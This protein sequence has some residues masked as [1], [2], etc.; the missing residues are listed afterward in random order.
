[1][2]VGSRSIVQLQQDVVGRVGATRCWWQ[3]EKHGSSDEAGG[4]EW[5]G[6]LAALDMLLPQNEYVPPS[7]TPLAI[8]SFAEPGGQLLTWP[9]LQLA[10]R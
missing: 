4:W 7:S 5:G 3:W 10:G 2:A 6:E 1:M 9:L 8:V